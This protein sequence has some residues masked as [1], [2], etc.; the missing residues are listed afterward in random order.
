[1]AV[2]AVVAT[3]Q[4]LT[5]TVIARDA[6]GNS[7]VLGVGDP[8]YAGE[9]VIPLRG[10]SVELEGMDGAG[11]S[12]SEG[13]QALM[14]EA[15]AESGRADNPE[16][17]T[18][19]E[20]IAALDRGESLDALIAPPAAGLEGGE[21]EGAGFVR[22]AR[23]SEPVEPINY[24][25]PVNAFDR[26]DALGE[27]VAVPG[28]E[29]VETGIPPGTPPTDPSVDPPPVE[30]PPVD[31]PPVDPP[32]VANPTLAVSVSVTAGYGYEDANDAAAGD[33]V[34]DVSHVLNL[35]GLDPSLAGAIAYSIVGGDTAYLALVEEGSGNWVVVLTEA[36]AAAIRAGLVDGNQLNVT[37][38]GTV[39]LSGMDDLV[40]VDSAFAP[41]PDVVVEPPPDADPTLT[42]SVV[43]S[44][45]YGYEEASEAVAGDVVFDVSHSLNLDGLDPSLAGAIAYSIVG[46]DTAYLALAQ[47]GSGNWVVVL[48]E[49]GAAAIRAGLVDG[50]QLNVT[51]EGTVVLSG[52]DDLVD[53][54]S[55]VAPVP[56]PSGEEPPEPVLDLLASA[57]TVGGSD[58][59][60]TMANANNLKETGSQSAAVSHQDGFFAIDHQGAS[61]DPNA[62][63]FGEALLFT[64]VSPADTAVFQ[65]QGAIN[66]GSYHLYD[67]EGVRIGDARDLA[68][69]V[70]ENGFLELGGETFS[71]IAFQG[72]STGPGASGDESAFAVKPVD[73][74]VQVVQGEDAEFYP[75]GGEEAFVFG[76][77][78]LTVDSDQDI[79]VVSQGGEGSME[80]PARF[81]IQGF[82]LESNDP[83]AQITLGELLSSASQETIDQYLMAEAQG[84]D[85]VLH[86][87]S[88]GMLGSDADGAD[89]AITLEGISMNGFDSSYDFIQ[90]LIENGHLSIDQ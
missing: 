69:D 27:T 2:N 57:H 40:D 11:V 54:G 81:V 32:P 77:N 36:G 73:L 23:I 84:E 85:T 34:F 76:A 30:P 39:V 82:S 71:F 5:G 10:A 8:V 78:F 86:I 70:D 6:E 18:A 15:L 47:D 51:I 16:I 49:A 4:A 79:F 48:T 25:F 33:V 62:I 83:G 46:G 58:V 90:T 9:E 66:G 61:D 55:G 22:V 67:A 45:G 89:Y 59:Q 29:A 3:V 17:P 21:G 26:P 1:M 24:T 64:L 87:S 60:G 19:E 52:M 44:T 31:P 20:V 35:D 13:Q 41:V 88:G 53:T 37:I 12:L 72:G 50:N 65:I 7:R 28:G 56:E 68:S 38:E 14:G 80:D 63:E 43:V 75:A 42:V 74:S